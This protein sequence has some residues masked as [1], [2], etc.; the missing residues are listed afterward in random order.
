MKKIALPIILFFACTAFIMAQSGLNL[1]PGK[2]VGKR[3]EVN[4]VELN[5]NSKV[6]YT[7][8]LLYVWMKTTGTTGFQV[9]ATTPSI[10]QYFN[11]PQTINVKGANFYGKAYNVP[12]ITVTVQLF[13]AGADS[14]PTGSALATTTVNVDSLGSNGVLQRAMFTNAIA[15]SAPYVIVITNAG[16]NA[17]G[18]ATNDNAANDG[19][20]EN[21]ARIKAGMT[22]ARILSYGYDCD[23]LI[24]PIVNYTLA[25]VYFTMDKT[26]INNGDLVNFTNVHPAIYVDRMYEYYVNVDSTKYQFGWNFGDSPT[27]FN[28]I[29]TSHQYAV[30]APYTITLG[31]IFVGYCFFTSAQD[32]TANIDICSGIGTNQTSAVSIYPNPAKNFINIDNAVNARVEIYNMLG[33]NVARIN[34]AGVSETIDISALPA[35]SYFIRIEN[36]GAVQTRKI[37]VRK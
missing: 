22:W 35:G 24:E 20:G 12:S 29:D 2:I 14:M 18:I 32:T 16:A 36:D 37:E 25:R 34:S 5:P 11:A 7:D 19:Q 33:M 30:A 10:A 26:C 31:D 3:G 28:A 1:I 13:L 8:T 4:R 21:L 15:V 23:W 9:S 17:V 6:P 27:L